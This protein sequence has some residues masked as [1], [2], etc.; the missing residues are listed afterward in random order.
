MV[1]LVKLDLGT[2]ARPRVHGL[3]RVGRHFKKF[4]QPGH[5][6]NKWTWCGPNL[7]SLMVHGLETK[8]GLTRNHLK[9]GVAN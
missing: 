6:R 8:S 5:T 3:G 4:T 1:N 9:Y 2:M 7:F